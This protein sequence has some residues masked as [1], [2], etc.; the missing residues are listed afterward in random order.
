MVEEGTSETM[1]FN[2]RGERA[3]PG[4]KCIASCR[5]SFVSRGGEETESECKHIII[6]LAC[7]S[8]SRSHLSYFGDQDV[9]R[10]F[11]HAVSK[12]MKPHLNI[13]YALSTKIALR[14]IR[15]AKNKFEYVD[16]AMGHKRNSIQICRL[17][18]SASLLQGSNLNFG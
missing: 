18:Q 9:I 3:R 12:S 8:R 1:I 16:M 7:I 15:G 2:F 5:L 4:G 10:S 14:G 6:L 13:F 17:V 11:R